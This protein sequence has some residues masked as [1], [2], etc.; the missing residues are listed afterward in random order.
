[1]EKEKAIIREAII[2]AEIITTEAKLR[3]LKKLK[4]GS[5]EKIKPRRI[6]MSQ[7][8]MVEDI[9]SVAGGSLHVDDIIKRVEKVHSVS[10]DR[11]SIVSALTK[12]VIRGDRFIRTDKNT[13][14]L[15]GGKK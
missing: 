12:K 8:D 13:F 14:S 5:I 1:M 10:I 11:E 3:A 15:K 4:I 9:L 2:D 6:G 7:V